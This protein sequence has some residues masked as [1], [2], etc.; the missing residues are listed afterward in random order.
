MR[1]RDFIKTSAVLGSSTFLLS[2]CA[3]PISFLRS[4][5]LDIIIKNGNVIDGTGKLAFKA[6]V[7][8][9]DGKIVEIGNLQDVTA[10]NIIDA[11]G[12]NI[13]PGF[14][15][16]HSHTDVDLFINPKAESK[17]RQGVTT[18]VSGQDGESWGPIANPE[19]KRLES[20]LADYGEDLSWR[21]L[22]EFLDKLSSKKFSVN[23]ANMVGLGSVREFIIGLD[24]RP[25]T[26][27]EMK[28]MKEEVLLAINQGALGTSTGLEYTP[29]SFASTEELIELCKAAPKEFRLYS[30]HMRNED[31]TVLEAID[32]AI[33]IAKE[34]DSRLLISHLKVSGKSNWHKAEA[35]LEKIDN[36]IKA[37]LEVHADRYTY[38][39]YHTSLANLF[40]LWSRDGGTQKFIERLKDS[41]LTKQLQEFAEKKVANLDGGWNGILISGIGKTEFKSYQGKTVEQISNELNIPPFNAAVKII[42][43]SE[44]NV[45]MVGFGMEEKSTETILAHPRVM[46]SSDAGAHA[47]YPPMTRNIAHPRA[48][49]TFPR[50]IA[51][52]V[53]ERKICSIEEMIKKMTSMPADK[54]GLKNIGR[55]EKGKNA[56]VVIFDYDRIQ[57]KATFIEP[58][59]YPDGIPYVIVNGIIVVKEGEHTGEMPG[60]VIR[61]QLLS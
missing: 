30:T 24:D 25:A 57:D 38:V 6:D 60:G 26:E 2:S 1:R 44:N 7:G 43:D 3:S 9:K 45:L 5:E 14:I 52:Y 18:E 46:I 48:Y 61:S 42:L 41:S 10:K 20:F 35:A 47:P 22:G 34:S 8:I 31:N 27:S 55:I 37:G 59:Q 33:K 58:H 23:L 29:G 50:A 53:R 39:A 15:D 36:A 56:D 40:P 19:S 12:L 11:K 17:I 28:R 4:K 49:G 51:K 13:S 21:T 16:I 54:L 32:E